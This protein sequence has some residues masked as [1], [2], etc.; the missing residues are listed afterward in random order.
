[1]MGAKCIAEIITISQI[2]V[3]D[4]KITRMNAFF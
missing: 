4:F 2:S 1:M 3:V